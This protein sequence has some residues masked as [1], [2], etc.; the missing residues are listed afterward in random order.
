MFKANEFWRQY[1]VCC[2]GL[3]SARGFVVVE[4][5]R[6][7]VKFRSHYPSHLVCIISGKRI[8]SFKKSC[9]KICT[10]KGSGSGI[11]HHPFHINNSRC[12]TVKMN[13]FWEKR[14]SNQ[15]QINKLTKR[16]DQKF[17]RISPRL[18]YAWFWVQCLSLGYCR[19]F[20]KAMQL[21]YLQWSK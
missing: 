8:L 12:G 5:I 21:Q 1:C 4:P 13:E 9:M 14:I 15:G 2:K 18:F 16:K 6:S 10:Y 17:F 20:Q 3:N 19:I 7:F 11:H